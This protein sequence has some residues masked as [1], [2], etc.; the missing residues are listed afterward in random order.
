M[1]ST[2]HESI[3][4]SFVHFVCFGV[5]LL[6]VNDVI[7]IQSDITDCCVKSLI[8]AKKEKISKSWGGIRSI[9]FTAVWS[10][11]SGIRHID[12]DGN[13]RCHGALVGVHEG[14]EVLSVLFTPLWSA[15]LIIFVLCHLKANNIL[16]LCYCWYIPY[17]ECLRKVSCN[18]CRRKC[19]FISFLNCWWRFWVLWWS[20]W[21][22]WCV[23][24][25][26]QIRLILHW[27]IFP[28]TL[29]LVGTLLNCQ[30]IIIPSQMK[31][32]KDLNAFYNLI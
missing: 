4:V 20:C 17:H 15:P 29:L 24:W 3:T 5:F 12:T 19:F 2:T 10:A 18:Y 26:C 21:Y 25:Y 9:L 31:Y 14:M 27:A 32:S 6:S 13:Q 28:L 22:W 7:C 1:L 30:G 23:C 16:L 11:P 8:Y